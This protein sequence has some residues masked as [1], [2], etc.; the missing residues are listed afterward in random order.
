[1][2]Q[3]NSNLNRRRF[4]ATSGAMLAAP[5]VLRAQG[6]TEFVMS[7]WLGPTNHTWYNVFEPW[8]E[9]V[10][11]L[12]EGRVKI[13]LTFPALGS[14]V[15]HLELIQTGTAD[16]GFAAHGYSG[17]QAF[18]RAKIGQFSFLGDAFGASHAY[19]KVYTQLLD[20]DQEHLDQGVHLM[21]VYQ[22]GPGALML[23]DKVIR[24]PD[25]YQGL[26]IRTPG[27]YISLL[28]EDLGIEPVAMSPFG[29]RDAMAAGELDGVAFAV[30]GSLTFKVE[31]EVNYIS[32][33][34]GGYYN[35]SF[36]AAMN[37]QSA[38]RISSEDFA[39]IKKYSAETIHVLA[40]KSYDQQDYESMAPFLE[41]NTVV[42]P[43]PDETLA[44]VRE[45][46]A[47]YE[48][49]WTEEIASQGYDG[50]KA[51]AYTRRITG[52]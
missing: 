19:S 27:G 38:D 31:E 45:I 2:T 17:D 16:L 29:V 49:R 35:T 44:H 9:G 33:V 14:P 32:T 39:T 42:E 37:P 8:A 7:M 6:T 26:R 40:G 28:M 13:N 5:S 36:F 11:Q 25:D 10:N 50:A 24:T 22:H 34:P 15:E 41:R 47:G 12:T 52:S 3:M 18:P 48:Q 46:A 1:M 30:G 51:L 43:V 4:I 21:G 23:K 20:A